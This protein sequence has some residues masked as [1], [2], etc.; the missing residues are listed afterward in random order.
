MRSA[1]L[2]LVLLAVV[3][4]TGCETAEEVRSGVDEVRSSAASVGAGARQACKAT[5]AELRSLDDLASR[6]ADDPGLRVQ[7]APQ[8]RQT[9]DRLAADAG[10][11]AELQPV[12]A[13]AREL[14]SSVGQANRAT[15]EV[16][17][18]QAVLAIRSAQAGCNLVG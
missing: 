15:I 16:T 14:A 17:A 2:A 8:V 11:R 9:V 5:E 18:R 7:L 4:T 12:V 1:L 10:S 3:G 6:L 13:A